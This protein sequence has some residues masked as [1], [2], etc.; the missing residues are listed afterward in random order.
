MFI[1]KRISKNWISY[2][3]WLTHPYIIPDIKSKFWSHRL[4]NPSAYH[5]QALLPFI[6]SKWTIFQVESP[7]PW[8]P[9]VDGFHPFLVSGAGL[10][11]FVL[12]Y[13]DYPI[14]YSNIIISWYI[15]WYRFPPNHHIFL[16]KSR[17]FMVFFMVLSS[18]STM[19]FQWNPHGN[20][21]IFSLRSWPSTT[22]VEGDDRPNLGEVSGDENRRLPLPG[23]HT[24][25]D[26]KIHHF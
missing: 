1:S 6:P 17:W 20:P 9:V 19:F 23:K 2:S 26:G 4:E 13:S 22:L 7:T 10:W 14:I 25:N 15:K 21:P 24:K 12:I 11:P 5:I 18:W 8:P 16:A 3:V